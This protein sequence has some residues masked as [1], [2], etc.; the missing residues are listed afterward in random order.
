MTDI[1]LLTNKS[2]ALAQLKSYTDIRKTYECLCKH[3]LVVIAENLTLTKLISSLMRE[4]YHKK[5]K[6][7]IIDFNIELLGDIFG[8]Y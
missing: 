5:H 1:Y 6:L 8:P 2:E 4:K 7:H 3:F